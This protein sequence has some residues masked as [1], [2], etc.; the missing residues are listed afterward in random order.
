MKK[1][2]AAV[3]VLITVFSVTACGNK[4]KPV[5][6]T[7]EEARTVMTFTVNG[8]RYEVKYELYRALFLNYKNQVDGGD[9]SVW[10]GA[11]ADKYVEQID[12][13]ILA[14]SAEIYSVF[15]LAEELGFDP[16]SK[17]VEKEIAAR[18]EM[19]VEGNGGDVVGFGGDYDAYLASLKEMNI[20]YS[21][22]TLMLRYSVMLE[23]INEYYIGVEDPALG[24]LDGDFEFTED[25]VR[26]YYES[27]DCVRVFHAFVGKNKMTDAKGYVEALRADVLAAESD[28][29]V[30]LLI[31]NRTTAVT[32][33]LL[34]GR[35]V[36]GIV[37]GRDTI[38]DGVY[39]AYRDTAFALKSG[40]VSEVIEVGGATPGYYVVY[41]L[42][43]SAEHLESCYETVKNSY[44]DNVIGRK[45]KELAE[46]ILVA[47]EYTD[48][49][50][51]IDHKNISI[52]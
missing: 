8:E 9:D 29:D 36:T 48:V 51:G 50:E 24:H 38:S 31:I 47:V 33:D 17:D 22:Q 14:R 49:F 21:V 11:D 5:K 39:G 4:Y 6:S 10:S 7:K 35:E 27:D 18:I 23:K 28:V 52:D 16:Y 43:K 1:I 45:L 13:L 37:I 26:E 3:I 32:S 15:A 42:E 19:S 30:A 2:L 40:E 12:E 41:S 34:N 20:N 44:L 25:D 46:K